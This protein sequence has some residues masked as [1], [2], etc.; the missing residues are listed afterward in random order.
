MWIILGH[1]W[2]LDVRLCVQN[3]HEGYKVINYV[4]D[5][6]ENYA[7]IGL[8]L[9]GSQERAP[10][11]TCSI[12][13]SS[14]IML[15]FLLK[16]LLSVPNQVSMQESRHW[17]GVN[18]D[19]M[20]KYRRGHPRCCILVIVYLFLLI[21][22]TILKIPSHGYPSKEVEFVKWLSI[23]KIVKPTPD[24]RLYLNRQTWPIDNF[25]HKNWWGIEVGRGGGEECNISLIG[26]KWLLFPI[27]PLL[28]RCETRD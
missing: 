23:I 9:T 28:L 8:R 17:D 25:H 11:E 12:D 27:S 15:I 22:I 7:C 24:S 26:L 3:E 16:F 5:F 4:C 1:T 20:R 21:I 13:L 18:E 14:S 6:V 19:L 10:F 2:C